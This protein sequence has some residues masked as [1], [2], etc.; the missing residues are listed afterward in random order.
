[1][2]EAEH[3]SR[4]ER[5]L[6]RLDEQV[7]PDRIAEQRGIRLRPVGE[8]GQRVRRE[9]PAR[10]RRPLEKGLDVDTD[11][12]EP[13]GDETLQRRRD[14]DRGDRCARDPPVAAFLDAVGLHEHA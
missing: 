2:L 1:M 13:R 6:V 8:R 10:E 11:P 12:V 14:L 5:A 7:A 3:A 4:S 9:E